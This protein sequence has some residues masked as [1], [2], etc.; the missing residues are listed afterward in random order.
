M[1][2]LWREIW[3]DLNEPN[4]KDVRNLFANFV[5]PFRLLRFKYYALSLLRKTASSKAP[6]HIGGVARSAGVVWDVSVS[7]N[8][9]R[10]FQLRFL[11]LLLLLHIYLFW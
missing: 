6:L 1:A 3:S 4:S 9:T 11:S 8:V 10:S 5:I 2:R 7:K